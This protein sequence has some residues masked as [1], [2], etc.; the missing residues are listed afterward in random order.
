MGVLLL[1]QVTIF[2]NVLV[3]VAPFQDVTE[4]I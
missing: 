1:R 2:S 3:P 4:P